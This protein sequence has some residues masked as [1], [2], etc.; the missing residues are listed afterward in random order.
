[1]LKS[2]R[3]THILR[4]IYFFC[5]NEECLESV[6]AEQR[7]NIYFKARN[8]HKSGCP[9]EARCSEPSVVP[10]GGQTITIVEPTLPIPTHLGPSLP[11]KHRGKQPHPTDLLALART[12]VNQQPFHP[13]TF[14]EVVT[15]WTMIPPDER[16]AR[17]LNIQGVESTYHQAFHF[18]ARGT[19]NI[20]DLSC[21]N[22]IVFGSAR[23]AERGDYYIVDTVKKFTRNESRLTIRLVAKKS[24]PFPNNISAL[25]GKECTL[26][27]HGSI[28]SF[29]PERD[30]AYRI[31]A[32]PSQAYQGIVVVE[33][34]FFP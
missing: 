31:K 14:R 12:V 15:A 7:K 17:Q 6:H 10:G 19:D 21:Q 18:L 4:R 30:T 34:H 25:V 13:G 24:N 33:G 20:N 28:P 27:W 23:V 26:F 8:K 32:D 3:N 11:L 16:R 9:N 22:G 1:M 29:N 5:P 2:R